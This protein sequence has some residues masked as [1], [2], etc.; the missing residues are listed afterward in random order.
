M[1]DKRKYVKYIVCIIII[2]AVIILGYKIFGEKR[3]AFITMT[4][5]AFSVVPFAVRFEHKKGSMERIVM[6]S[7]LIALSVVLRYCFSMLPHF[8]PVTAI[9]GITG[10]Y[11]GGEMGFL[12]GAFSAVIS[13][14]I[15]GQGP[16]TPFQMFAWGM[17]GLFAGMSAKY[18]KKSRTA[19]VIYG[20]LSGVAYS[21]ILDIWTSIWE[22]G[23][24]NINRYIGCVITSIPVMV[25][26]IISN[27][28]FLLLLAKPIGKKIER[29]KIK[30]NIE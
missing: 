11:L 25:I 22:D 10:I 21:M 20:A 16:W 14:F 15:F 3:Y 6:L 5:A 26:Y 23:V 7:V 18:L 8:K 12:C 27:I 30:M 19:L 29:V 1:S 28:I 13:N 9:V 4:I 17:T 2:P 24:F